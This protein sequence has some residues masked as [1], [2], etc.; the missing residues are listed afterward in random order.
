[1][2]HIVRHNLL[3]H[4]GQA[5][6]LVSGNFQC[7]GGQTKDEQRNEERKEKRCMGHMYHRHGCGR[8]T[9]N[10]CLAHIPLGLPSPSD[11]AL[12]TPATLLHT[13]AH[14]YLGHN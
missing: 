11:T 6:S 12:P 3:V 10:I 13:I 8:Y 5:M 9:W 1:M 2:Q 7:V 14:P 4:S